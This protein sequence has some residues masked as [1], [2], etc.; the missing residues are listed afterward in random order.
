MT[1]EYMAELHKYIYMSKDSD[2]DRLKE[3]VGNHLKYIP[4]RKLYRYRKCNDRELKLIKENSIWISNPDAFIDPFDATIPM[5]DLEDVD[6]YYSFFMGFEIAYIAIQRTN[7]LDEAI[8]SRESFLNMMYDTMEK[9]SYEEIQAELIEILGEDEYIRS[10]SQELPELNLEPQINV[11]KQF[12]NE[13]TISPR[14]SL[15]IASF[16][17]NYD[18]RNMWEN[19]ADNYNGLCVE[20]N[21]STLENNSF[22]KSSFDILHLLPVKYYRKMPA[23]DYTSILQFI[24]QIN[25]KMDKKTA[26]MDDFLAQYYRFVTAKNYDYRAEQEWRLIMKKERYGKYSFPYL[27]KI[28]IGKDMN[29]DNIE[30]VCRIAKELSVPVVKQKLSKDRTRMEYTNL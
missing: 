24:I 26:D 11:A 14:N 30:I 29:S 3:K 23:F 20:Y 5:Q 1:P 18:N 9:Y 10:R 8:P 19:Y 25:M 4:R 7:E 17:T 13:L 21:F 28:I 6:F 27:S 2:V 15:A 12:L 22:V 16:S